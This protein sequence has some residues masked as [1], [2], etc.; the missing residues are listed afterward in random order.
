METDNIL[1]NQMQ[2]CRPVFLEQLAALAVAL[3]MG[4]LTV[5]C[6]GSVQPSPTP[7]P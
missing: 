7:T 1:T 6:N 4:A 3:S 5:A 2:V